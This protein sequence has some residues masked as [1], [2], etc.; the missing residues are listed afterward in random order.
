MTT[1]AGA[2]Q[3]ASGG[4]AREVRLRAAGAQA[5]VSVSTRSID[6]DFYVGRSRLGETVSRRVTIESVLKSH[7][8]CESLEPSI[9]RIGPYTTE[10]CLQAQ[11]RRGGARGRRMRAAAS[12][13]TYISA[14]SS[15]I[16]T[17]D[18]S[19]DSH[20]PRLSR[21]LPIVLARHSLTQTRTPTECGIRIETRDAVS[22]AM[23]R[24]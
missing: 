13:L 23:D 19:N 17:L 7:G 1:Q 22:D 12:S 16:R 24:V 6:R 15:P 3:G 10:S 2:R 9:V 18:S 4:V 11:V 5:Q 21:T 8:P 20:G 14:V